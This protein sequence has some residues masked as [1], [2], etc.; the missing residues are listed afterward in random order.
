MNDIEFWQVVTKFDQTALKKCN[1]EVAIEPLIDYLS[2]FEE[3]E[4]RDFGNILA[5]TFI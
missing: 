3:S 5:R 2:D 4:I 1:E